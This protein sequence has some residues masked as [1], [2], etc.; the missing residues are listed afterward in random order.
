MKRI[1][2]MEFTGFQRG[3]GIGGWLS[4]YENAYPEYDR[5]MN[6]I[7]YEPARKKSAGQRTG[8]PARG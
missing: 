4:N 8:S 3:M 1:G 2:S 6:T 5:K 7:F